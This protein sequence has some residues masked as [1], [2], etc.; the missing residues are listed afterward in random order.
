MPSFVCR[1]STL[2]PGSDTSFP[3]KRLFIVVVWRQRGVA[4]QASASTH[5]YQRRAIYGN[6]VCVQYCYVMNRVY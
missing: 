3:E 2:L 6:Y 5:Q 4:T 1:I